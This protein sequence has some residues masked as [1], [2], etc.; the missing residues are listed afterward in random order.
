VSDETKLGESQ[1]RSLEERK[2]E[3]ESG[4]EREKLALEKERFAT[5]QTKSRGLGFFNTNFGLIIT[6]MIGIATVVVSYFQLQISYHTS[7]AQLA[8]EEKKA[9]F[10]QDNA[11]RASQLEQDKAQYTKEKEDRSFQLEVT[12]LFLERKADINTADLQQIYYLRDI[13]MAT[14]PADL[15]IK[16]TRKMADNASDPQI[17]TAWLD[18]YVAIRSSITPPPRLTH[19]SITIDYVLSVFPQLSAGDKQKRLEDLLVEIDKAGIHEASTTAALLSYILYN[20]SF[21]QNMEENLNYRST[22]RIMQIFPRAFTN[23][24]DAELVVGKPE[25]LA[26]TVYGTKL[27]NEA[28]GDGWKYRGRGYL[29]TAGKSNYVR[30]SALVNADLVNNPD[31]LMDSETAA[32]EAAVRFSQLSDHSL[33]GVIRAFNGGIVGLSETQA[34][35]QKL[36]P[37]APKVTETSP[38]STS[39]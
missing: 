9:S 25:L 34:I 7:A 3:F 13:V 28:V 31:A 19:G 1:H 26:N 10:S 32:K 27:G 29:Q 23:P 24:A 14:L 6:A 35:F 8:L 30:S 36:V 16:I 11:Q 33:V 12:R 17:H 20:T 39:R 15:G 37:E 5:E 4:L 2:F 21:F 18:G 22:I 38:G